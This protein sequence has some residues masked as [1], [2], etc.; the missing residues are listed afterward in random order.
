MYGVC[1]IFILY[2]IDIYLHFMIWCCLSVQ[3]CETVKCESYKPFVSDLFQIFHN[4]VTLVHIC[5]I[6]ILIFIIWCWLSVWRCEA[7]KFESGKP[8]VYYLF[9]ICSCLFH[10]CFVFV[11]ICFI[12]ILIFII[13][14]W[15]SVRRCETVK[16][17]SG[18]PFV[19]LFHSTS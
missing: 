3:R 5:F 7:V 13:W 4:C 15:L 14:C 16:C 12:F 17:E 9:H 1:F 19:P 6:Y 10:I 18:K 2:L 11:H 8:F